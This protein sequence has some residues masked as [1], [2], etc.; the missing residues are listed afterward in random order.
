MFI[1]NFDLL[2]DI[3]HL[4]SGYGEFGYGYGEYYDLNVILSKLIYI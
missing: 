3:K 2:L 4:N 1:S